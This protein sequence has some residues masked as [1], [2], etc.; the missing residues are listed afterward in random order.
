M[1][2]FS[3]PVHIRKIFTGCSASIN[4]QGGFG[5][6]ESLVAVAILGTTVFMLLGSLSTGSI[7]VGILQE[8]VTAENL[9]RAQLE[10][11]RSLPYI[12]APSSYQML[13]YVPSGYSVTAESSPVSGRDNNIQKITVEVFREGRRLY[14]IEGFKVNR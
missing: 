5:L 2:K 10:Y 4:K 14:T 12:Q 1:I 3:V 13:D 6:V 7:S 9:G 8:D 11:T